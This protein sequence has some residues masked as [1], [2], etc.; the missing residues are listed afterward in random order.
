[1]YH[2]TDTPRHRQRTSPHA[3]TRHS[4]TPRTQQLTATPEP[5]LAIL[6]LCTLA[7][8]SSSQTE[9]RPWRPNPI[10]HGHGSLVSPR[11]RAPPTTHLTT[12]PTRIRTGA[13]TT[14][15]GMAR[16]ATLV[17]SH[18]SPTTARIVTPPKGHGVRALGLGRRLRVRLHR[19]R[20]AATS[21]L[22]EPVPSRGCSLAA[23]YWQLLIGG[24]TWS[25]R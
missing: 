13:R 9:T 14:H 10:A 2:G 12:T 22:D 15:W 1:M 4:H 8:A 23:A 16:C 24:V 17:S 21:S 20:L 3:R 25:P 19:C 18:I 5:D 6:L 7:P 11:P